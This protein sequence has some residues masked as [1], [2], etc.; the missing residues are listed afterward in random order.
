[1]GMYKYIRAAW[2][3]PKTLEF[4]KERLIKWR[5]EPVT[6]RIDRPTRLDRA[7][8][9]GYRA[10]P[11]IFIVRQ[12]IMRGGRMRPKIRAGRRPKHF[13]HH[14]VLGKSYQWIAE[15]RA[16]RKFVNCEVLNSYEV[17]KD[18]IYFWFEIIMVDKAHPAIMKDRTLKWISQPN[19]T[20]RVYRGKTASGRR[21]RGILTHKGK[22][23]EK[24][25]P[26]LR[27]NKGR[28]K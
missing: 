22:G 5:R 21:S 28:G 25:R 8:S 2:K 13:R 20:G 14:M 6:I 9:L 18:G 10:K 7:R 1:M 11:G 16:G 24:L 12:R 15:E 3:K 23:A 4:Y 26:S 27:A 19:Q 17:A